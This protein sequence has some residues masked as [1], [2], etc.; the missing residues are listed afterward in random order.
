MPE[1]MKRPKGVPPPDEEAHFRIDEH[2]RKLGAIEKSLSPEAIA[3]LVKGAA[4]VMYGEMQTQT[5]RLV[6]SL[7]EDLEADKAVVRKV[8]DLV[9]ELRELVKT[10]SQLAPTQLPADLHELIKALKSPVHQPLV[11]KIDELIGALRTPQHEALVSEV[12]ELVKALRA[13]PGNEALV[14]ELRSLVTALMSPTTRTA[15]L[16]LP[17]GPATMTV[18]EARAT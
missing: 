9:G 2:D 8:S 6:K 10:M 16:E 17:S 7:R 18:R 12:R 11:T 15:T 3:N 4:A 14:S 13:A 1:P 5:D